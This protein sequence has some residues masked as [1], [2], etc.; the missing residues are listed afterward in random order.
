MRHH[1][2]RKRDGDLEA[3]VFETAGAF[4]G[5]AAIGLSGEEELLA[6]AVVANGNVSRGG[7]GVVVDTTVFENA[8]QLFGWLCPETLLGRLFDLVN[9]DTHDDIRREGRPARR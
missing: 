2:K 9:V 8:I 7:K 4:A 1:D 6:R 3:V 5:Y